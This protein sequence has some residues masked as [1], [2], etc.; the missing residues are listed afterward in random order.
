MFMSR[1]Q[2]QFSD[3]LHIRYFRYNNLVRES[4]KIKCFTWKASI[5]NI[6]CSYL[7][8][9]KHNEISCYYWWRH[10]TNLVFWQE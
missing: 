3:I 7:Y 6:L 8:L 4:R 2:T 5:I 9:K 1:K 10:I